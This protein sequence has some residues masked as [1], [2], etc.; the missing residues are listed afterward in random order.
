MNIARLISTVVAS[1]L[2]ILA[3]SS[4]P[5]APEAETSA[6]AS[7][8]LAH[9]CRVVCPKCRPNEICPLFACVEDCAPAKQ[10]CVDNIFCAIGY[11]WSTT[12][13]SCEPV[14]GH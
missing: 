4:A 1:S 9:G 8:A 11:T 2:T 5:S 3:C 7:E 6:T 12:R 13:C 10:P 14:H